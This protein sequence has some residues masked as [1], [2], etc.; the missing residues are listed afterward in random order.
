M[1]RSKVSSPTHPAEAPKLGLLFPYLFLKRSVDGE[2]RR[3]TNFKIKHFP[4]P[5]CIRCELIH[6]LKWGL[7]LA[8]S[9]WAFRYWGSKGGEGRIIRRGCRGPLFSNALLGMERA[10]CHGSGLVS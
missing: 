4:F 9:L 8:V 2:K 1:V 10:W 5:S 3:V 7:T 6:D